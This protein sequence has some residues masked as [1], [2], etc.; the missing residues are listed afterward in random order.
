VD[1]SKTVAKPSAAKPRTKTGATA[2]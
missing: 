1:A 2:N